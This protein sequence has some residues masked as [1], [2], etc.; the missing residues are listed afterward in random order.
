[1]HS[2]SGLVKIHVVFCCH[3]DKHVHP[4]F[5]LESMEDEKALSY[6]S[7]RMTSVTERVKNLSIVWNYRRRMYIYFVNCLQAVTV[8]ALREYQIANNL[9]KKN[10][11][12][13]LLNSWF[14][15]IFTHQRV[16]WGILMGTN[17]RLVKFLFTF[18]RKVEI[19]LENINTNW[20]Q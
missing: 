18:H 17:E 15:Y 12:K 2:A 8:S 16:I 20:E 14:W 13:Y 7:Y 4:D 10:R 19:Q 5:T 3:G 9:R 1:M 6:Y 11:T